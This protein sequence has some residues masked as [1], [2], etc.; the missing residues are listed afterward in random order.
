VS[1]FEKTSITTLEC[2]YTD[3][4]ST[5]EVMFLAGVLTCM[6]LS[7]TASMQRLLDGEAYTYV[8]DKKMFSDI[9]IN[10]CNFTLSGSILTSKF[11]GDLEWFAEEYL[12][13]KE[14][15]NF[16]NVNR[17]DDGVSRKRPIKPR[18]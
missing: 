1:E 15:G 3:N 12:T 2:G 17:V 11:A 10:E 9:D 13:Q 18:G 16:I 14:L 4:L 8:D 7:L 5:A 6:V